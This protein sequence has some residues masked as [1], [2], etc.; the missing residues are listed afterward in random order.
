MTLT[1]VSSHSSV[2]TTQVRNS[3]GNLA[4]KS[5]E[6]NAIIQKA[7]ASSGQITIEVT[8]DPVTSGG[9]TTPIRDEN[10]NVIGSHI[11]IPKQLIDGDQY[12]D[13]NNQ[14]NAM[15]LERYLSHEL[16]HL[17][18]QMK[19]YGTNPTPP[20]EQE[21]DHEEDLAYDFED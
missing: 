11:R 4:K 20:T 17:N 5:P 9:R 2:S 7:A 8:D 1:Y 21:A 10:G 6:V 18:E 3:A 15:T 19:H 12:T 16:Y 14:A 13:V